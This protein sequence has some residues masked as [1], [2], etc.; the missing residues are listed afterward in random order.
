VSRAMTRHIA[1]LGAPSSIG[2]GPYDDGEVRHLDRTPS[3]LRN[4]I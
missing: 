3:V 2:V 4:R 1:V